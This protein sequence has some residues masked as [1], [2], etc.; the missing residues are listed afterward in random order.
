MFRTFEVLKD[1]INM[2]LN[3]LREEVY[4]SPDNVL[5]NSTFLGG[6][7]DFW[8]FENVAYPMTLGNGILLANGSI[9]SDLVS[10]AQV[11]TDSLNNRTV[12]Q[13]TNTI[14]TQR[15]ANFNSRNTGKYAI[16]FSYRPIV[17]FGLWT[18][19]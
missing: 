15:N 4:V 16:S 10:G 17:P 13:V 3:E 8:E 11:V 19:E 6:T 9:F 1:Q 18:L 12:L 7:A 5:Q 2:G 14:V